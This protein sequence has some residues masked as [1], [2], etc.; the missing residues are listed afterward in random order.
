MVER[1][2]IAANRCRKCVSFGTAA[3]VACIIM[4]GIVQ[5]FADDIPLESDIRRTS[6]GKSLVRSP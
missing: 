3:T 1:A 5:G 6:G 4:Y 2:D